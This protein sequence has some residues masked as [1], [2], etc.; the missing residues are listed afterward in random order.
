MFR[1][2]DYKVTFRHIPQDRATC[3]RIGLLWAETTV[4]EISK[5]DLVL[6][7]GQAKCSLKDQFDRVHGRRL[8]FERAMHELVPNTQKTER[9]NWWLHFFVSDDGRKAR[10]ELYGGTP[11][12]QRAR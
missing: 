1:F 10:P 4:C 6:A 8:S 7:T 5:D 2:G 11:R 3:E 9:L 12:K